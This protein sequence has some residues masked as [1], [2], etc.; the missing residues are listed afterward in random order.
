MLAFNFPE[1]ITLDRRKTKELFMVGAKDLLS[2]LVLMVM[3][4]PDQRKRG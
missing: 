3:F 1:M 4:N 2:F